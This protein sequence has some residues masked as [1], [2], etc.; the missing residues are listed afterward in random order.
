LTI[1]KKRAP[2]RPGRHEIILNYI[3][4]TTDLLKAL[5]PYAVLILPLLRSD[6]PQPPADVPTVERVE[7][8][9][10]PSVASDQR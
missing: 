5:L 6:V 9:D 1:T 2:A 10:G 3:R 8:V 7:R 4:A